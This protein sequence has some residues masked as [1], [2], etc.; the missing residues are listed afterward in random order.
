MNV[1]LLRSVWGTI[2][3]A[4]STKYFPLPL[5]LL[6]DVKPF[7][8]SQR[9]VPKGQLK[10]AQRFNAGAPRAPRQVPKGRLKEGV[11]SC[12]QSSLRDSN[13]NEVV[14]GVE[15]PG[16]SRVVPSGHRSSNFRKALFSVAIFAPRI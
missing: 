14:P 10:I 1:C 7:G 6:I 8:N 9:D 12:V 2:R 4:C 13:W 11:G 5:S 3:C 16:Y 15:T